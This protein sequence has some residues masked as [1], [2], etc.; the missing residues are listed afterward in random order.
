MCAGLLATVGLFRGTPA[1]GNCDERSAYTFI[2]DERNQPRTWRELRAAHV[3]LAGCDDGAVA[4]WFSDLVVKRLAN[5]WSTFPDLT[6]M[7]RRDPAFGSWVVS[8]IDATCDSSDLARAVRNA[9]HR[10]TRRNGILCRRIVAAGEQAMR[11]AGKWRPQGRDSS[12][13]PR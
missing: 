5:R 1:F 8:H 7:A 12:R 3:R 2:L 6:A 9:R 10:C 4:Q 13:S 11:E